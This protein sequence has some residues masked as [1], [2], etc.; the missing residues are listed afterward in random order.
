MGTA[1]LEGGSFLHREKVKAAEVPA[2]EI[3]TYGVCR[4]DCIGH[5]PMRVHVRDGKVVKTS[6]LKHPIPEFE[7]ICQRGLTQVQRIYA[8]NRLQHPLRRKGERGAGQWEEISW[9]EAIDEICTR[10]QQ[11]Q[12]DYGPGSIAFSDCAGNSAIDSR[13]YTKRLFHL[14]G[15]TRIDNSFD[16]AFFYRH[17]RYDGGEPVVGGRRRA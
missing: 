5:C 12:R 7:R 13:E 17:Y 11:Y 10:W 6:K 15:A 9:D 3:I 2:E 8:P 4:G 14:M 16:N 1:W